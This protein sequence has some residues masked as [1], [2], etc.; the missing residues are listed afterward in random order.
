[1]PEDALP[2]SL[3]PA[4]LNQARDGLRRGSVWS[5]PHQSQSEQGSFLTHADRLPPVKGPKAAALSG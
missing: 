5:K 4:P 1:M 3:G 2:T